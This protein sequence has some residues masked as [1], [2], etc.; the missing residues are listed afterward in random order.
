MI[1][2]T[3]IWLLAGIGLCLT[4]VFLPTAFIAF[5]LG[6][7]ALAVAAIAPFTPIPVQV[8]VWM[9]LSTVLVL[10]SRR[11]VRRRAAR[12]LDATEAETLTEIPP[13]R[14]GR[15]LYEGNSWSAKCEDPAV[16][17]APNQRVYVVDRQGTTLIVL[18]ENLL[19]S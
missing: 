9:A 1:T 2:P 6:I 18:P 19:H 13:G 4:E 7:S 17:I 8:L 15:V 12:K 5:V 11:L 16:A 14:T 3:Y 10:F